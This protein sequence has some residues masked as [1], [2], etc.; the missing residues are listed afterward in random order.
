MSKAAAIKDRDME[1]VRH[2]LEV[3]RS[4]DLYEAPEWLGPELAFFQEEP[5]N[6]TKVTIDIGGEL[7]CTSQETLSESSFFKSYFSRWSDNMTADQ[8][9][10]VDRNPEAFKH[11]LSYLRNNDYPLPIKFAY[12]LAFYGIKEK[13]QEIISQQSEDRM[14]DLSPLHRVDSGGGNAFESQ[15]ALIERLPNGSCAFG[16]RMEFDLNP[17]GF[18]GKAFVQI[19]ISDSKSTQFWCPSKLMFAAIRKIEL[20][21]GGMR[22]CYFTG[23]LLYIWMRLYCS[24][25]YKLFVEQLGKNYLIIPIDFMFSK[26]AKEL[27]KSMPCQLK[28]RLESAHWNELVFFD[29][30]NYSVI[31]QE[32]NLDIRILY[33]DIP[34]TEVS[35]NNS[36]SEFNPISGANFGEDRHSR[37]DLNRCGIFGKQSNAYIPHCSECKVINPLYSPYESSFKH[38]KYPHLDFVY[39][40]EEA[41]LVNVHANNSINFRIYD[42]RDAIQFIFI[43]QEHDSFESMAS[44]RYLNIVETAILQYEGVKIATIDP[45]QSTLDK[46]IHGLSQNDISIYTHTFGSP[47]KSI[48][49][50]DSVTLRLKLDTS[51]MD[52]NIHAYVMKSW[53]IKPK[54]L[55]EY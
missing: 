6:I 45:I 29:G 23:D 46:Y 17:Q 55:M 11:I 3:A 16:R 52:P 43:I 32:P 30:E 49:R 1:S 21:I 47:Y 4:G 12:E 8:T 24:E 42:M 51:K 7:F 22:T 54:N 14:S 44:F 2:V 15:N 26:Q 53:I 9:M 19:H 27:Y 28:I 33:Q 39:Q 41:F 5:K 25:D 35:C 34:D 20:E 38:L 37:S 48:L 31:Y 13:I 36:L 18:I 40:G 10:F 50:D